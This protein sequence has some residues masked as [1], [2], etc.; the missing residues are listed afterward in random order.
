MSEKKPTFR[1]VLLETPE[2]TYKQIVYITDV[3]TEAVRVGEI[4]YYEDVPHCVDSMMSLPTHKGFKAVILLRE[5]TVNEIK[6]KSAI[7]NTRPYGP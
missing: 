2:F 4:I 1:E 5:L 6:L 7:Q 3:V